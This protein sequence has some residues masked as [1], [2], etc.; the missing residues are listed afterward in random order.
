MCG[1]CCDAEKCEYHCNSRTNIKK[2]S[3][4][5][6]S[7]EPDDTIFEYDEQTLTEISKIIYNNLTMMPKELIGQMMDYI[8]DREICCDCSDHC[9]PDEYILCSYC[10]KVV[11]DDCS[12]SIFIKCEYNDCYY[13]RRG[14]CYNNRFDD[15]CNECYVERSEKCYGCCE[16]LD[17]NNVIARC[18]DCDEAFC[19]NC[20]DMLIT[21]MSTRCCYDCHNINDS[22]ENDSAENDSAESDGAEN[23]SAENDGA[24]SNSAESDGAESDGA[25]SD[26][27]ESDGAESDGDTE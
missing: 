26:G 20:N 17:E 4:T 8:D 9:Q 11:C 2:R 6:I 14:G 27:A 23:D 19:E 24:E 21:K 12:N 10:N 22:A 16:V 18:H 1:L 15:C 13:C 25:E 3:A 5:Q 7:R